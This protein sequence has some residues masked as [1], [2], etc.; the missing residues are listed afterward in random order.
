MQGGGGG[1]GGGGMKEVCF[2]KALHQRKYSGSSC[3]GI[4]D[5]D[6]VSEYYSCDMCSNWTFNFKYFNL[7]QI[8]TNL[9][10]RNLV[11]LSTWQLKF[12]VTWQ[13]KPTKGSREWQVLQVFFPHSL[14]INCKIM[15]FTRIWNPIWSTHEFTVNTHTHT[16]IYYIHCFKQSGSLRDLIEELQIDLIEELQNHFQKM[17]KA[18]YLSLYNSHGSCGGPMVR[19]WT[20]DGVVWV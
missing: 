1:G 13:T 10:Q 17:Q 6:A 14:F 15:K 2:L 20:P 7:S 19:H 18:F 5:A 4:S 9:M 8:T 11:L 3:M 16:H 12:M